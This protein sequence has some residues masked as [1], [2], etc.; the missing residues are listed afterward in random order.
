LFLPDWMARV[1]NACDGEDKDIRMYFGVLL[2]ALRSL[3]APL[4]ESVK[5]IYQSE[6]ILNNPSDYWISVI[7]VG[8]HFMLNDVMGQ[9]VVDADGAGIIVARLMRVADV[10]GVSPA[11]LA[12]NKSAASEVERSLIQRFYAE[13]LPPSMV[14]PSVSVVEGKSIRLQVDKGNAHK[15]EN[16]EYFLLDDPKVSLSERGLAHRVVTK[17]PT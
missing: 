11:A 7:N 9:D 13:K 1:C 4:M 17:Y 12:L 6:A 10:L 3:D 2:A 14:A 15:T 8:R 5:V 16:D